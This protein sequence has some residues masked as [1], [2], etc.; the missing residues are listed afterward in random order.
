MSVTKTADI[1]HDLGRSSIVKTGSG[2]PSPGPPVFTSSIV[3]TTKTKTH[4]GP[5]R[6][7]R[8]RISSCLP[9]STNFVG[10]EVNHIF[11]KGHCKS[12][13]RNKGLNTYLWLEHY[14]ELTQI[15]APPIIS[16]SGTKADDLSKMKFVQAIRSAQTTCQG[17][18][19]LGEIGETLHMLRNPA[20]ALRR[21]FDNYFTAL[22]KRRRGNQATRKKILAETWLEHSFGWQPFLHDIK[23]SVAALERI[24]YTARSPTIYVRGFGGDKIDRGTT[25]LRNVAPTGN[26]N[27]SYDVQIH[28]YTDAIVIRRGAVRAPIGSRLSSIKNDFG[29]TLNNFVPTIWELVPWSFAVDYFT[30]IGDILSSW[31]LW[32]ADLAWSNKTTVTNVNIDRVS[33]GLNGITLA[34][35][36]EIVIRSKEPGR[37]S[38]Y[39]RSVVRGTS[40][41]SLIPSLRFEIPGMSSLKWINLSALALSR[42]RLTPY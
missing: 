30:N 19:I 12:V 6:D 1:Y 22:K 32:N 14:G 39:R 8:R 7:F 34:A 31:S 36:Q 27:L 24:A 16:V 5:V 20:K 18:V 10:S 17:G 35:D 11:D 28:E 38:S 2:E 40:A 21:G 29:F 26:S 9:A 37:S 3:K 25:F 15:S 33:G 41:G 4:D 42:K 23:D 13:T